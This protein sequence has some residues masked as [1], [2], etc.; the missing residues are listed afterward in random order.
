LFGEI[1]ELA[2]LDP[3]IHDTLKPRRGGR[4]NKA[5]RK[6]LRVASYSLSTLPA[7][8]VMEALVEQSTYT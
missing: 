3:N 4:L 8:L 1:Y 5:Y 7:F 2:Y 6:I